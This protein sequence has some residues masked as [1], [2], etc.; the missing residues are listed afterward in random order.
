M[1]KDLVIERARDVFE[2]ADN[3]LK[4][5]E[6]YFTSLSGQPI[7]DSAR[8]YVTKFSRFLTVKGVTN[9]SD[10][11]S[12]IAKSFIIIT[13]NEAPA[14][15]NSIEWIESMKGFFVF[16]VNKGA[17]VDNIFIDEA[18]L[19][20][21][22]FDEKL[23]PLKICSRCGI[24]IDSNMAKYCSKCST[25]VKREAISRWN[26]EN[27]GRIRESMKAWRERNPDKIKEYSLKYNKQ[28]KQKNPEK[29]REYRRRYLLKKKEQSSDLFSYSTEKD[30]PEQPSS[31]LL[32]NASQ[33]ARNLRTNKAHIIWM[34]RQIKRKNKIAELEE[35]FGM[36]WE[37]KF[38]E[39]YENFKGTDTAK[40]L[41]LGYQTVIHWAKHLKLQRVCRFCNK[42]LSTR[43][44]NCHSECKSRS[45]F[46]TNKAGIKELLH[47]LQLSVNI[48][49]IDLNNEGVTNAL[50]DVL[51]TL[52]EREALIIESRYLNN[53][54]R[55]KKTLKDLGKSLGVTRERVRQIEASTI[56]KLNSPGRIRM[57]NEKLFNIV[58]KGEKNPFSTE[59]VPL[60]STTQQGTIDSN[61]QPSVKLLS[62]IELSV[63][64]WNCLNS[65]GIRTLNELANKTELEIL[66]IRNLGQGTLRALRKL[67]TNNGLSFKHTIDLDE[68]RSLYTKAYS[69]KTIVP[70]IR[71]K[72]LFTGCETTPHKGRYYSKHKSAW[73]RKRA[74]ELSESNFKNI[75]QPTDQ[76]CSDKMSGPVH[77]ITDYCNNTK[78]R[79]GIR[80]IFEF[81]KFCNIPSRDWKEVTAYDIIKFN[82]SRKQQGLDQLYIS[83][84][85]CILRQFFDYLQVNKI[86]KSNIARAIMVSAGRKS[87]QTHTLEELKEAYGKFHPRA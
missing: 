81:A 68:F 31:Q 2:S 34:A 23:S 76:N 74:T 48:D 86:I 9:W 71:P 25:I 52:S 80:I 3:R 29:I 39:V 13:Q 58:F 69:I 57:I 20:K 28:W 24:N 59:S 36:C 47:L 62:E 33:W 30:I 55:E 79:K 53:V 77:L 43:E 75:E 51:S 45:E 6:E 18:M 22:D 21:D 38:K 37:D 56:D 4:L 50:R 15:F 32:S 26:K 70:K 61:P 41:N 11:T 12:S 87:K 40:L 73:R 85:M 78:S 84:T 63:R 17:V 10:V 64:A 19:L 60:S 67:L 65:A 1:E 83:S 35:R 46:E 27:A 82:E 14:A 5:A 8:D 66:T 72:C 49:A 42:K 7:A 44:G 54:Y 16:L